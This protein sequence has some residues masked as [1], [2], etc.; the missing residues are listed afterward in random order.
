MNV[1][2]YFHPQAIF[3]PDGTARTEAH[4]GRF[5]RALAAECGQVTYYAHSGEGHGIENFPLGPEWKVRCVDLGPRH[6]YPRMYLTPWR[7][8]KNFN[9]KADG[10]DAMIV[11]GPTALLPAIS[12]RCDRAGVPFL[13]LIVDDTSNWDGRTG[14]PL[15]RR[16]LVKSWLRWQERVHARVGRKH[17][18]MAIAA[19]NVRDPRYRRTAIV[20]TTSLVQADLTGPAQRT[21]PFP[22]PGERIRLLYTGRIASE[23]GLF[24]LL[25][26][27][28]LLIERGHNVELQMYGALYTDPTLDA[29]TARAAALGIGDRLAYGGFLEAGAPLQAAYKDAD[30]YVLPTHG[31]GSVT[32]TI[33]ESFAAGLP[34]V[35]TT[36]RENTQ[37]LT[38]GEHAVL[39]PV[40]DPAA[41]ADGIA[42]VI[43]DS[44]LRARIAD[45]GFTWVGYYTNE[46]SSAIVGG[47]VRDEIA[48]KKARR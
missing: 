44:E 38:D 28:V 19:S 46:N 35:T 15:W 21:R 8:L 26:A 31:E 43:E 47:H 7:A 30:I 41:L 14:Y 2:Y 33:K 18:F 17:L 5:I 13:G 32:R 34:V 25:D 6:A 39:V 22:K 12:H 16:T 4:W 37:F 9:P 11:R 42:R 36:I 24:E 3:E 45:N 40:E 27:M 23:K 10:L 29:M 48:R 20:P 1:G